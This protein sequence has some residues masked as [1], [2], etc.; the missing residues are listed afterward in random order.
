MNEATRQALREAG[1][2]SQAALRRLSG[3]DPGVVART[4][5]ALE[6]EGGI[7]SLPATLVRCLDDYLVSG[8]EI[9]PVSP[10]RPARAAAPPPLPDAPPLDP[11]RRAELVARARAGQRQELRP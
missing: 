3:I 7:K 6:R 4:R 9:A 5:K 8:E 2:K 10:R 11:A 1:V